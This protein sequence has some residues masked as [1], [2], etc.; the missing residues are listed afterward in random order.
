MP[1]LDK[2]PEIDLG[3]DEFEFVK[4]SHAAAPMIV[5]KAWHAVLLSMFLYVFALWLKVSRHWDMDDGCVI[6]SLVI[7]ISGPSAALSIILHLNSN[8]RFGFSA[9]VD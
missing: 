2:A 4:H 7:L 8:T 6:V 3:K 5:N 1:T 9:K